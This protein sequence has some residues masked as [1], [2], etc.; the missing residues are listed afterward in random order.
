[1]IDLE[2]TPKPPAAPPATDGPLPMALAPATPLQRAEMAPAVAAT[3]NPA[4]AAADEPDTASAAPLDLTAPKPEAFPLTPQPN[5]PLAMPTHRD[6]FPADDGRFLDPELVPVPSGQSGAVVVR[7][8]PTPPVAATTEPSTRSADVAATPQ[9]APTPPALEAAEAPVA[10]APQVTVVPLPKAPPAVAAPTVVTADE[11]AAVATT[12]STPAAPS[13]VESTEP[14][15]LPKVA[16]APIAGGGSTNE[17]LE[18]DAS[19]S[20][21][22]VPPPT[23]LSPEIGDDQAATVSIDELVPTPNPLPAVPEA[24]AIDGQSASDFHLPSLATRPTETGVAGFCPVALCDERDLVDASPEFE[25][26]YLGRLYRL[27][28]AESLAKFQAEPQR[29]APAARGRDVVM[30]AE[31]RG[32]VDGQLDFAVWYRGRLY[33]FAEEAT[34]KLFSRTPRK[35]LAE[36]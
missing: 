5:L 34:M 30:L 22:A 15:P 10:P 20:L 13:R 16:A 23:S 6:L 9:T 35:F 3:Q 25:A 31:G 12:P 17:S 18:L 32:V 19:P 36:N 2:N 21:A 1:M 4:P 14:R 29:Y 28:D 27:A 24:K 8:A 33:L 26:V 7:P 11:P